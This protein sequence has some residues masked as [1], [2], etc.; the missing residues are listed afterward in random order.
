MKP[1]CSP[2]C[3]TI[4]LI[5][6]LYFPV[7]S[8]DSLFMNDP[9]LESGIFELA[10]YKWKELEKYG[11]EGQAYKYD[12]K[13]GQKIPFELLRGIHVSKPWQVPGK[14]PFKHLTV[15]PVEGKSCAGFY[16]TKIGEI[17]AITKELSAGLDYHSCYTF[18]LYLSWDE[19]FGRG[20][21]G[22]IESFDSS[23]NPC[24][25]RIWAGDASNKRI[26]LLG[27]GPIVYHQEWKNYAFNFQ[28][29]GNYTHITLE[30]YYAGK[31][32]FDGHFLLDQLSPVVRMG[33][34]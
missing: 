2:P 14:G 17:T 31:S 7:I 1:F 5:L 25:L 9:G 23:E 26:Q 8:Q 11:I 33:C 16:T 15:Q 28:A 18:N 4:I 19:S 32:F 27:V 21:E 22:K 6:A 29:E 24:V 20:L 34:E 12:K 3:W 10:S 13:T 30:A